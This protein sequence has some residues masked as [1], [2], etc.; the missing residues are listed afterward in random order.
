M[1][2]RFQCDC[3]HEFDGGLVKWHS[4]LSI[5]TTEDDHL[6]RREPWRQTE[7][8]KPAFPTLDGFLQA[9]ICRRCNDA[10]RGLINDYAKHA[11]NGGLDEQSGQA[12]AGTSQADAGSKEEG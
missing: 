6:H 9:Q 4:T 1:A 5:V 2:T 11:R 3:C 10:I 12:K 8:L 7:A